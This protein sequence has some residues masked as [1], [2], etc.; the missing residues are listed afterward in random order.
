MGDKKV[1]WERRIRN[2][3]RPMFPGRIGGPMFDGTERYDVLQVYL[4]HER[5]WE[6]VPT[7]DE[8]D[9]DPDGR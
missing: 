3:R 9:T 6:D 5:R 2:V 7:V 1:R 8:G 4:D